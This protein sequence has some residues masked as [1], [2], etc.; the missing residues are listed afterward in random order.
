M[1][2]QP[3]A[4][5][6]AILPVNPALAG[7][8]L[9]EGAAPVSDDTRVAVQQEVLA[10]LGNPDIHRRVRL[11]AGRVLGAVGDPRF[12]PQVIRGVKVILP[13]LVPVPGWDRNNRQRPLAMGS[14]GR[15]G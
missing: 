15:D 3:D 2:D 4:F 7:R 11:Q 12:T 14:A 6:R 1:T 13:D 8:C 5:V 9:S 10:D